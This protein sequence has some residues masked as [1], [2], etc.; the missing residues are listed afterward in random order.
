MGLLSKHMCCDVLWV[1]TYVWKLKNAW[2]DIALLYKNLVP[3]ERWPPEGIR[4][5]F[6]PWQHLEP[7][8]NWKLLQTAND[9]ARI[10][11]LNVCYDNLS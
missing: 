5:M 6:T 2:N 3:Y 8:K 4:I 1:Q 11:Q 10:G 9:M 7:V